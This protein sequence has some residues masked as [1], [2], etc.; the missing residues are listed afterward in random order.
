MTRSTFDPGAKMER[1]S[2][3][4]DH[5]RGALK[6]IGAIIVAESQNAFREQ[7]H[8]RDKWDARA[9]VNVYGIVADFAKGGTP[10]ARRFERRP[11]LRDTGRLGN[12]LAFQVRGTRVVEAGTNLD[13][14][15]VHQYGGPIESETITRSM[16]RALWRWLKPK[17]KG[18]K[19]SLGFLLNRKFTGER[20]K[21]EVPARPFV[22]ITKD[23]REDV[24][25]VVGVEIMEAR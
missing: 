8:G 7:K 10:P 19:A 15:T 21:G 22:G 12:S 3:A 14:A 23:T 16:Q 20:L 17:D 25:E 2:K 13:Y 1:W 11:V 5:P 6:Q 4:L 18:I 9:S 24:R